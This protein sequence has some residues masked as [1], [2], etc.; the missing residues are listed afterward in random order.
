MRSTD[1]VLHT[2]LECQELVTEVFHNLPHITDMSAWGDSFH[3][4]RAIKGDILAK[5]FLN[6]VRPFAEGH[7]DCLHSVLYDT[8]VLITGH[9]RPPC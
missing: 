2:V 7:C 4:T 3:A 5:R 9:V 8:K 6:W 1:I